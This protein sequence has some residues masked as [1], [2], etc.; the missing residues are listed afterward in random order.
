[1][2]DQP[3][4]NSL[5]DETLISLEKLAKQSE[6]VRTKLSNRLDR[7]IVQPEPEPEGANTLS[8]PVKPRP[9]YYQILENHFMCIRGNIEAISD[10]IDRSEI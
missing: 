7:Y 4:S 6:E 9:E 3:V 10:L 8:P 5:A 2:Q 1:M